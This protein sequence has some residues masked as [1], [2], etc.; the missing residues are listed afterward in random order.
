MKIDSSGNVSAENTDLVGV[1]ETSKTEV[2]G[3]STVMTV[4]TYDGVT[5]N[6]GEGQYEVNLKVTITQ[7]TDVVNNIPTDFA[8]SLG[9]FIAIGIPNQSRVEKYAESEKQ[10]GWFNTSVSGFSGG[11][12]DLEVTPTG[13]A[14]FATASDGALY[15]L[16]TEV[17]PDFRNASSLQLSQFESLR[18]PEVLNLVGASSLSLSPDN[19]QLYVTA[20][21]SDAVTVFNLDTFGEIFRDSTGAISRQ[22]LPAIPSAT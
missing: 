2:A 22:M 13:F 3:V 11:I 17:F 4:K 21:Q 7:D 18:A 14:V 10:V 20:T 6:K 19:S 8:D 1:A 16:G 15:M 9:D 12:S 5:I